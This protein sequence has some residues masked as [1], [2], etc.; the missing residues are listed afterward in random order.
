LNQIK[1]DGKTTEAEKW[2]VPKKELFE[3]QGMLKMK[4]LEKIYLKSGEEKVNALILAAGHSHGQSLKELSKEIPICMLDIKGK[5]L[6]QRQIGTLNKAEIFDINTVIGHQKEK[7]NV[8]GTSYII[9]DEYEKTGILYSLMCAQEKLDEKTLVVFSDVLFNEEVVQKLLS[10]EEDIVL[11]VDRYKSKKK[12]SDQISDLIFSDCPPV[13][14][15]RQLHCVNGSILEIGRKLDKSK[16]HYEFAGLMLLSKKGIEIV[17]ETYKQSK[18]KYSGKHFNESDVFEKA[19]L[20]SLLQEIIKL[21]H[22]ISFV[23]ANSG[24]LEIHSI[25]HYKEACRLVK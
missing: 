11:L 5:P 4:E 10:S 20:N 24:W 16:V 1:N 22:N 14:S 23:E 25:D 2:I 21:N 7:V 3:L 9:N 6:L 13:D 15:R 8:E 17:K 19:N 12:S 18:E